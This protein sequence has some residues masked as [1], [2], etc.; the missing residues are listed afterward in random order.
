MLSAS[1]AQSQRCSELE[2]DGARGAQSWDVRSGRRSAWGALRAAALRC[3]AAQCQR[4]S[5]LGVPSSRDVWVGML[6]AGGAQQR[7]LKAGG[8]RSR[9]FSGPGL[10]GCGRSEAGG[11]GA[12]Q[13]GVRLSLQADPRAEQWGFGCSPTL[14][15]WCPWARQPHAALQQHAGPLGFGRRGVEHGAHRLG[16]HLLNALLLQC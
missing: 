6:R 8:A 13:G 15:R 14:S 1:S 12:G 7:M 4:C 5:E 3:W 16:E 9:G 2:T 11:G 10:W